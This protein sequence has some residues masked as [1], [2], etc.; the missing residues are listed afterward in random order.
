[1]YI[2]LQLLLW[3]V[4]V[5][6][7]AW[8][9][10]SIKFVGWKQVGVL[11]H[12]GK[13]TTVHQSGAMILP[14]VPFKF[15]GLRVFELM[16]LPKKRFCLV[17]Q[18]VEVMSEDKQVLLVD[19]T[20][21]IR[22]PF[23]HAPSII[24]LVEND[25]PMTDQGLKDWSETEIL[26]FVRDVLAEHGY[27]Y[28]LGRDQL[29]ALNAAVKEHFGVDRGLFFDTGL[30]G[31]DP[32]DTTEGS[33]EIT[34]KIERILPTP[35]LQKKLEKV[36][37]AVLDVGAAK[38]LA[39]V[40]AI[41]SGGPINLLMDQW[42]TALAAKLE[43]TVADATQQAHRNGS[44]DAQLRL[45]KD[46]ILANSDDLAVVRNEIGSPDGGPLPAS[47]QYVS[48]GDG[49]GGV[50]VMT[51]GR[52]RDKGNRDNRGNPKDGNESKTEEEKNAEYERTMHG[53]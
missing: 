43:I 17:Y 36:E 19:V 23:R 52:R 30:C 37:T 26:S 4:V 33:G 49:G 48:V 24:K 28:C 8:V 40:V 12:C 32:A 5:G 25:V 42:I 31:V 41:Q 10:A 35:E 14:W 29:E 50:G 21:Y 27:K 16:R 2:L 9:V 11:I 38:S 13:P 15:S 34:I 46:L 45:Y 3:A 7:V 51:N 6:I 53:G 39:E 44:W 20:A 18:N 47:I 22:I 1:M